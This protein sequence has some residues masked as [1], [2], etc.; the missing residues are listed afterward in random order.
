[1]RA[2]ILRQIP[3]PHTASTVATYDLALIGMDDHI[4]DRYAMRVAPLYRT[5]PGLPD[6]HS[7]IL[8]ARNHPFTLAV[9]R[10]ARDVARVAFEREKRVGVCRL[11]VVEFDCVVACSSE[12][13]FVWGDAEAVDLR[14]GVLD[15]AGTDSGESLPKSNTNQQ[16]LVMS[17]FCD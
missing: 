11:D 2:I 9:K 5:A 1:M 3:D 15:C 16:L 4:I 14:V 6:L 7:A 12:E 10:N 8:R 17:R 13:A